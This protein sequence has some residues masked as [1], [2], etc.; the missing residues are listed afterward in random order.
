MVGLLEAWPLTAVGVASYSLFLWHEPLIWW[1]R[2]RGVLASG[3][4]GA[5]VLNLLLVGIVALAASALT[6]RFVEQPALRWKA[7]TPTRD[8]RVALEAAA[9]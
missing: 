1:L 5:F 7:R 3:G 8:E 9:P 2:D 4:P 6:Y